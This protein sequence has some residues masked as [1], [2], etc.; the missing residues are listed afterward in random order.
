VEP[1][2]LVATVRALLRAREAEA[3]A[4]RVT[5][6]WQSTFDSIGDGVVI[7]DRHGALLRCNRAFAHL[8]DATPDVLVGRP[9][10]PILPGAAEPAE[11]WPF[12]KAVEERR[13]ATAELRLGERWYEVVAD[14]VFDLDGTVSAVVRTVK[15]ITERKRT[16]ARVAELLQL[17]QAAREEAERLNRLKDEF[18]ATLS[19][20]LR[21]PLNAIVGWVQL[22]RAGGL[23]EAR[24]AQAVETIA[25]N[26][27]QQSQ[28]ISDMLDVSRIVEGKLRLEWRPT[29]LARV[30]DE[31]WE[32]VRPAAEAKGI[33]LESHVEASVASL[34]GDPDRLQQ[35]V[36]N[37]LSNAVKW[38]PRGGRIRLSLEG[39]AATAL[40]RVEDT[41]PGIDP[42]FLPY[43][44][45][46]F[47]QADAS[48]TRSHAGL[49]L[50]LAIVRHLV[51]L[52]GGTV[53]ARNR[54]PE[55]GA[56]FEV[57]LP[58][59]AGDPAATGIASTES[60]LGELPALP[61]EASL[62]GTRVLV[63]EDDRDGRSLLS[64]V[65]ERAGASVA[66]AASA[67]EGLRALSR[68]RPDVLLA[69]IEMP[70]MDGDSL[71][72]AV[73]ALP[74]EQG[75]LTPAAAV[76]AYAG[77]RDRKRALRAGF[78][79]HVTK[80]IQPAVLVQTVAAL[81]AAAG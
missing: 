23:D 33:S 50:G 48:S 31:A 64:Y 78:Q 9:A 44:F 34:N 24:H 10:V 21:T 69:D 22:L 45:E 75:G 12:V 3:R 77:E 79:R 2:V 8:A 32:T 59:T 25:R 20:E 28:L 17:E 73:R 46:R 40:I 18:L 54:S 58:R 11:G 29:D 4:R 49:G 30:L 63:V 38:C 39:D 51:E 62:E 81:K 55:P 42:R 71:I 19:H 16:E 53:S 1:I 14:P 66:T 27:H 74:A 56:C 5:E 37:L 60:T 47:R 7:Y 52:H 68:E 15:D 6:L 57:R 72:A 13:R 67:A 35:V 41:G 43:V 70:G 80:P 36:W 61:A 26:A 65:L 76:T